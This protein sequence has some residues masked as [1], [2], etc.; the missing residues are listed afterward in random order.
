MNFDRLLFYGALILMVIFTTPM[1]FEYTSSM[2]TSTWSFVGA[3]QIASFLRVSAFIY[4]IVGV[5]ASS[6]LL[7]EEH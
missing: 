4:L 2:D 1:I 6:Y 7:M 5:A 3:Q